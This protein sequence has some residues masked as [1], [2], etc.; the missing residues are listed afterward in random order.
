MVETEFIWTTSVHA[1]SPLAGEGGRR[2]LTDEG[3]RRLIEMISMPYR[4]GL[5]TPHPTSLREATFSHKGRRGVA[6]GSLAIWNQATVPLGEMESVVL[7]KAKPALHRWVRGNPDL[8]PS[9]QPGPR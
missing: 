3:S 6:L 4:R 9:D 1:P 7:D 5:S 8:N 2:S